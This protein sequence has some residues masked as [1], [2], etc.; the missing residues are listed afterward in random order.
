MRSHWPGNHIQEHRRSRIVAQRCSSADR[1]IPALLLPHSATCIRPHLLRLAC[2]ILLLVAHPQ[3]VHP[4]EAGRDKSGLLMSAITSDEVSVVKRL[5]ESGSIAPNQRVKEAIFLHDPLQPAEP[6]TTP[7]HIAASC[8]RVDIA[9]L[10]LDA[11]AEPNGKDSLGRTPL[12]S[13]ATSDD[14]SLVKLLLKSGADPNIVDSHGDTALSVAIGDEV[15]DLL[16]KVGAKKGDGLPPVLKAYNVAVAETWRAS[17]HAESALLSKI[18]AF[19]VD[20][21]DWSGVRDLQRLAN[22]MILYKNV[23]DLIIRVGLLHRDVG[24]VPQLQP[25]FQQAA[26]HILD[27]VAGLRCLSDQKEWENS[28]VP[29]VVKARGKLA[30]DLITLNSIILG[31]RSWSVL[32]SDQVLGRSWGRTKLTD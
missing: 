17:D 25:K 8:K 11:K 31:L 1:R 26:Q 12:H 32:G 30:E 7:L 9:R 19:D 3:F 22:R 28:Q 4:A 2:A 16:R 15:A 13:A 6:Y 24:H 23:N 21:N 10:L 29:D 5:I 18:A 20:V 14:L 27:V